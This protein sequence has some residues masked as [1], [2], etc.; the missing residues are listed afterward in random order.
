MRHVAEVVRDSIFSTVLP[1]LIDGAERDQ[2]LRK[3]HHMFQREAGRASIAIIQEGI[4]AG[5][6]PPHLDA[7]LA[8]TALVGA[9][10]YRRLMSDTP[11]DPDRAAELVDTVL[12]P[13]GAGW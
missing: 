10:F 2:G 5:D 9:L 8:H 6:F 4:D 3:I 7:E 1:G 12:G 11:F 13:E